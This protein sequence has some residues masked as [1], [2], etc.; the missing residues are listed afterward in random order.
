MHTLKERIAAQQ[1]R[2]KD[3]TDKLVKLV[4]QIDVQSAPVKVG[5]IIKVNG[6]AHA[7]RDMI[8]ERIYLDSHATRFGRFP[9]WVATGLIIR[10]DG[11]TG[12]QCGEWSQEIE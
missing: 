5:D 2:I 10:T 7:G 1:A 6:C 3:E 12:K 4:Q 11:T 8:V 9:M